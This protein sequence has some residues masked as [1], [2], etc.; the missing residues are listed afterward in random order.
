MTTID[1]KLASKSEWIEVFPFGIVMGANNMRPVMVFKDKQEKRVLPVWL[2]PMDA[3]IAVAQ[4][5]STYR[6]PG[7]DSNM[8]SPHE[9]TWR[10]LQQIGIKLEKCLFKNVTKS[11]QF[12][13][14]H[15]KSENKKTDIKPIEVKADDA[16]SFCLRAG[17]KFFATMEYIE[18]SR[19]LESEIVSGAMIARNDDAPPRYLN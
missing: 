12:L 8:G 9:I 14:L 1:V 2:S 7:A 19:V 15:F 18:S 11:Q 10:V 4:S 16:I 13:E 17:C 5:N 6:T 3:G